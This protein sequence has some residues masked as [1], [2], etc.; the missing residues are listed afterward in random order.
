MLLNEFLE[1]HRKVEQL[2]RDFE[3][4]FAEQHGRIET[5][6]SGLE[7]LN[8]QLAAASSSRG[9]LEASQAQVAL[10]GR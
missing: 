1:E 7:R 5:L 10:K 2:E 8:A 6:I 3:S 4:K 9:G